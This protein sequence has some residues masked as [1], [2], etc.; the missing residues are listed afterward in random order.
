MR[1]ESGVMGAFFDLDSTILP[2]PSLEWRFV[3]YLL[4]G[5]QLKS[6]NAGAWVAQFARRIFASRHEAMDANKRYLAGLRES[7]ARDW[8]LAATEAAKPCG[9]AAF[10]SGGD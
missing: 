1:G 4:E 7:L 2:A 8:A 5:N 10:F 9:D 3:G 6:A